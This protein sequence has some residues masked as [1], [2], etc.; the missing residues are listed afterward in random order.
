MESIMN[1]KN[2]CYHYVVEDAVE[3]HVVCVS[4]EEVLQ[5]ISEM[6]TGKAPGP[7]EVSLLTR[8]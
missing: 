1:E 5:A 2:D 4:M 6:K 8:E 7:S 3:V